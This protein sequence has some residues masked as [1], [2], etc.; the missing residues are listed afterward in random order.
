M[1][2]SRDF[3]TFFLSRPQRLDL[4][5]DLHAKW[6]RRLVF[7]QGCAFCSKSRYFSYPLIS[8][9]P[10]RSWFGKF[11]DLENFRSIWPLTLE[12]QRENTPYSSLEPNESGIVN[13]QIGG[14]KLKY[15]L[16][17]FTGLH[18]TWYRSCAM[19]IQHCVYEHNVWGGISR[20]PLEIETLVQTNRKWPMTSRMV[21]WPVQSHYDP[22]L[23]TNLFTPFWSNL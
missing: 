11:L 10:K 20:K 4:P 23:T 5:T 22:E 2:A 16:K 21:T 13:R 12:V 15:V 17:F 6:L 14:K 8:R 18:V 9:P 3:L 7:T 1:G 19:T